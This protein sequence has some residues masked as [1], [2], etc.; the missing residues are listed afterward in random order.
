MPEP[1]KRPWCT[2]TR[3]AP[4]PA[5]CSSSA[6]FAETP[7]DDRAHLGCTGDLEAV[8]PGIGERIDIQQLV[9]LPDEVGNGGHHGDD[10]VPQSCRRLCVI[11]ALSGRGAAW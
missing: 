11:L 8:E 3:S 10:N 6:R 2:I 1:Q 7:V 5:A 9:E 4:A